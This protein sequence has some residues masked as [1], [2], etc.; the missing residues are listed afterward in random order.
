[1]RVY[2]DNCCYNRPY[3]DQTQIRISIESQAKIFIQ[4]VIKRDKI[5][6]AASFVL[7]QENNKNPFPD[8]KISIADFLAE[9]VSVFIASDKMPEVENIATEIMQTGIK[10]ADA[11]HLACAI[12]A[13]C[14][15][16][17]TTDDRVLKF[18][19]DKL[20]ILNPTDFLKVLEAN[21]NVQH[22]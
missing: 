10:S 4:N 7:R 3:D 20:K 15:Y 17:L 12:L 14:D 8:K 5:E 11:A 2:L 18:K 22:D 9:N 1:M 6:L 21:E 13:D 16:F 19:S